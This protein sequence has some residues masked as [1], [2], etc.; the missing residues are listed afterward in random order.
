MPVKTTCW[1]IP[2]GLRCSRHWIRYQRDEWSSV[3]S[4]NH[5]CARPQ[6][7][8]LVSFLCFFF[9]IRQALP[10]RFFLAA[11]LNP[12]DQKQIKS[13]K[14][15]IQDGT[16]FSRN[17]YWKHLPVSE[18]L[19]LRPC[20]I[21]GDVAVLWESAHLLLARVAVWVTPEARRVQ[22][23]YG[24]GYPTLAFHILSLRALLTCLL[25]I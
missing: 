14:C 3:G 8:S 5:L 4:P 23:F 16:I 11:W 2:S 9:S 15:A 10:S 24:N 7:L 19:S 25:S 21:L 13:N 18:T 17:L 12:L 6:V 20:P 1:V 22:T